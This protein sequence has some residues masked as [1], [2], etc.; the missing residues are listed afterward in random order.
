MLFIIAYSMR[1]TQCDKDRYARESTLR[2]KSTFGSESLWQENSRLQEHQ[3]R[4]QKQP[5][6]LQRFHGRIP[7]K[8]LFKRPFSSS[9]I[10]LVS[11]IGT[12]FV[13][14]WL[15]RCRVRPSVRMSGRSSHIRMARS[16]SY[17]FIR[18]AVAAALVYF[19]P[20]ISLK[21]KS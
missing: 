12:L 2:A 14:Q 3:Q 11:L 4:C 1:K 15:V 10:C 19:W 20:L 5:S 21:T 17:H 8:I 18:H 16:G 9:G 13:L 7:C 6:N